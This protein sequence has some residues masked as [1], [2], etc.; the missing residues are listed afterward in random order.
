MIEPAGFG[1]QSCVLEIS[2]TS[3]IW[4]SDSYK[5]ENETEKK[6][7]FMVDYDSK[8]GEF[9]NLKMFVLFAAR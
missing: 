6:Y 9:P 1:L 7:A 3:S 4:N 2:I 8:G 5:L